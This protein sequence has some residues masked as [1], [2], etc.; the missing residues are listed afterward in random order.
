MPRFLRYLVAPVLTLIIMILG[1]K[2]GMLGFAAALLVMASIVGLW[3]VAKLLPVWWNNF[4]KSIP[5]RKLRVARWWKKHNKQVGVFFSLVSTLAIIGYFLFNC[6]LPR[7]SWKDFE[8]GQCRH[9]E[10]T[11]TAQVTTGTVQTR[12]LV[13]PAETTFVFTAVRD[14]FSTTWVI[15]ENISNGYR[16]MNINAGD[17]SVPYMIKTQAKVDTILPSMATNP[18]GVVR[19]LS[20][21]IMSDSIPLKISV[22]FSK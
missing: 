7:I 13:M 11:P 5:S 6:I 18:L 1:C 14:S 17:F 8:C 16:N 20:F 19:T 4:K 10:S 22:K 15:P 12:P 2:F 21:K 9:H 3:F